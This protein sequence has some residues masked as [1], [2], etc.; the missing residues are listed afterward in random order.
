MKKILSCILII[1]MLMGTVCVADDVWTCPNC[2]RTDLT[3]KFCGS[4]GTTRPEETWTCPN[5]GLEGN[6]GNFCGYCAIKRP[7]EDDDGSW[8]CAACGQTG[9]LY[10]FCINCAAPREQVIEDIWNGLIED[11]DY[12]YTEDRCPVLLR[13]DDAHKEEYVTEFAHLIR[14]FVDENCVDGKWAELAAGEE[15]A[16][17]AELTNETTDEEIAAAIE[18]ALEQNQFPIGIKLYE[19]KRI[20]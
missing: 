14:E 17:A 18:A 13:L 4:C 1:V 5:C 6:T 2:G 10:R 12:E 19:K 20:F 9:N 7:N 15:D 3:G 16:E 8:T 11:A